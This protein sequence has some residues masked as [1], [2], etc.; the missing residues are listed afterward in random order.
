MYIRIKIFFFKVK[1]SN[2]H[3]FLC[4]SNRSFKSIGQVQVFPTYVGGP[5]R[6]Y[7]F[8]YGKYDKGP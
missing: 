3:V 7:V 2:L 8:C 6:P 5:Q 1:K 4:A